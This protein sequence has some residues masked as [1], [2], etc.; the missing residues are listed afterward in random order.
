MKVHSF[1]GDE[2]ESSG[3]VNSPGG[4]ILVA[5]NLRR[6][7][8]SKSFNGENDI[9]D[10]EY[11]H[12]L[13]TF[14]KNHLKK[15][16]T[17]QD[18]PELIAESRLNRTLNT[19]L[20]SLRWAHKFLHNDVMKKVAADNMRYN[21][22]RGSL[23]EIGINYLLHSGNGGVADVTYYEQKRYIHPFLRFLLNL[24]GHHWLSFP[25]TIMLCCADVI[26][27]L[28][29]LKDL[30]SGF[31]SGVLIILGITN[32]IIVFIMGRGE[33]KVADR[34]LSRVKGD[35]YE[36]ALGEKTGIG[37]NLNTF[38]YLTCKGFEAIAYEGS[39]IDKA[40]AE[41]VM[42]MRNRIVRQSLMEAIFA[43]GFVGM[44]V[45]VWSISHNLSIH[46][47]HSDYKM[48]FLAVL[49]MLTKVNTCLQSIQISF[50]L[51]CSQRICEME[52]LR[53][54]WDVRQIQDDDQAVMI[55]NVAP[56]VKRIMIECHRM[57]N[58][59]KSLFIFFIPTLVMHF[60]LFF[61]GI[62]KIQEED[63]CLPF[64][65]FIGSIQPG[66]SVLIFLHKFS[67]IN[68]H[69]ERDLSS[70]IMELNM[71]VG[72]S[73]VPRFIIDQLYSLRHLDGNVCHLFF[74]F[75]PTM[76]NNRSIFRGVGAILCLI[77]PYVFYMR[78]IRS[79]YLCLNYD[80]AG[81]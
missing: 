61:L 15:N 64:W 77:F 45:F 36:F 78:A 68:L 51:R 20:H 71:R 65:I 74:D 11:E 58:K 27:S 2:G 48:A 39:A 10:I 17:A 41:E 23:L 35:P 37:P 22:D 42:Q 3:R 73:N 30:G 8:L 56:R 19:P 66:F 54:Q 24:G 46:S 44:A 76:E 40:K 81:D 75:V 52:I 28:L 7:T 63:F 50:Y 26:Y 32:T 5:N 60:F 1:G 33:T 70:D 49:A 25:L 6:S 57:T 31:F 80:G 34:V 16:Y 79:E 13:S 38:V 18:M 21:P 72:M 55:L 43:H 62:M 59:T 4:I 67:Q 12:I 69:L 14:R 9:D 47:S 29:C 53:V